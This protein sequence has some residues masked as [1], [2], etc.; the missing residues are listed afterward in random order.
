MSQRED[1]DQAARADVE[2]DVAVGRRRGA[3]R[4]LGSAVGSVVLAVGFLASSVASVPWNSFPSHQYVAAPEPEP[5][6]V[7]RI[8]GVGTTAAGPQTIAQ[9]MEVL[10]RA[11]RAA[12]SAGHPRTTEIDQAAAELGMLLAVYTAQQSALADPRP[13]VVPPEQRA[14]AGAAGTDDT[15]VPVSDAAPVANTLAPDGGGSPEPGTSPSAPAAADVPRALADPHADEAEAHEHGDETVTFE[16]VVVAA[17]RLANL[18]DPAAATYVADILPADGLSPR[19]VDAA[20]AQ[21]TESL[22]EVVERYAGSLDGFRNGR[23]PASALCPLEFAPGHL[24]RCDAAEQ[25][26]RL[27]E[28]YEAKFGVPIPITDSYRSYEAQVAVRAAKPHLA[29]VPG[30]SNHGWGIAVDLSYPISSGRSAEYVWLRVNGPDYGWDNPAWA[31]PNGSKPEP[32]HFEFFAGG[33]IP[34][35]A[36]SS[37]DVRT[38]GGSATPR[39]DRETPGSST[40]PSGPKEPKPKPSDAPASTDSSKPEPKPSDS[41]EP[42]PKPSDSPKPSPSPSPST[43]PKPSP[44][45][46]PKPSPSPSAE[47]KPSP[48]EE[49]T[50][51]TPEKAPEP[52]DPTKDPED[53]TKDPE[54]PTKDPE[55]PNPDDPASRR[56]E[57]EE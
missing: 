49:P 15:A 39:G 1:A 55:E 43:S 37:S 26:T 11:E 42:K 6:S 17:M 21:L 10:E 47:P 3:V 33:P 19:A 22:L 52:E 7:G 32:W 30:T 28:A 50:E 51:T 35:R 57:P 31:R 40:A 23:I 4:V 2:G 16:D 14:G 34:D 13:G 56:Q 12:L 41:P 9:V 27:S 46:S 5:V 54:D 18:L 48:S 53:P 24:L 38:G 8:G 25:L 45:T 44:S 20:R 29:A 36:W